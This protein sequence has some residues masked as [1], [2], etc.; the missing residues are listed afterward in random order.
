MAAVSKTAVAAAAIVALTIVARADATRV[1]SIIPA[2]TEMLFAMGAGD[3]V[4]GVGSYDRFPPEV[5]KLPRVGAL[6]DPD[7]ER[8]IALRPDLVVLYGTQAELRKSLDRASI[9]YYAY[10][11]RGLADITGTMRSL[12]ARVGVAK[13]AEALAARVER[14]LADV[15]K[16]VAGKPRPRTLL[17]FGRDTGT[18]R[19]IDA[20]GGDGFLHDMLEAAGGADVLGDVHQQSVMMSTEMI[21]GR[22][23][24]VIIELRYARGDAAADMTA[25]NT[26]PS[27]PAVR[28][29]RVYQLRGEEFVVPGP[30]VAAA[31]EQLARTLHPDAW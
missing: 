5:D 26:L 9:P 22:A 7:V 12:G 2:T 14:Q 20:S 13:Q 16:R 15:R 4:V 27:V 28:N 21:L 29:R 24:D 10:T 6:L 1:V 25:W 31:T 3:R 8:I 23:P 19:N 11:H 30:R 17:V 18:L